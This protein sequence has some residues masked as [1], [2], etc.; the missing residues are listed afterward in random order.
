LI[1][2]N[3]SD[4]VSRWSAPTSLSNQAAPDLYNI[5]SAKFDAQ[6]SDDLS[7]SFTDGIAGVAGKALSLNFFMEAPFKLID[8][9]NLFFV[10][11][12]HYS[13]KVDF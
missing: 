8:N 6:V 7:H 12:Q 2:N 5:L 3:P 10:Y 9:Y 1:Q 13:K 11:I 4:P